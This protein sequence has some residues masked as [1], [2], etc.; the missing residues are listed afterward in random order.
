MFLS[1]EIKNLVHKEVTEKCQHKEEEYISQTFLTRISDYSFRMKQVLD[2]NKLN[3][4][5]PY[6]HFKMKTNKSVLN[7]VTPNCYIYGKNW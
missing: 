3:D 1:V 7:L 4:R 6:L 5:M 2:L